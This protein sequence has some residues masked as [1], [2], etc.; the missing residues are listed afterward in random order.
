MKLLKISQAVTQLQSFFYGIQYEAGLNV[1]VSPQPVCLICCASGDQIDET[2][3]PW[4]VIDSTL[5]SAHS[6]CMHWVSS[7]SGVLE[8]GQ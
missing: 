3:E 2:N 8:A 6:S 4:G 5:C 1:S 7:S